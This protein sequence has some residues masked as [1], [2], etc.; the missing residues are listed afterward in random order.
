[1]IPMRLQPGEEPTP[2]NVVDSLPVFPLPNAVFFPNTLL[3]LH[4]FEPRYRELVRHVMET[5]QRMGVALLRPG[6]E[7]S[8]HEAPPIHEVM[9][10]G[11]VV[12]LQDLPDG[13]SNVLLRGLSRVRVLEELD[14]SYPFRLMRVQVEADEMGGRQGDA[15]ERQI[16]TVRQLF[17][18]V[19]ARIPQ[20]QIQDAGVLFAPDADPTFVLDSIASAVPADP[21]HKQRLLE[22]RDLVKRAEL[23]AEVLAE[24]VADTLTASQGDV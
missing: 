2:G 22:E 7:E 1:M 16:A 5:D 18:T 17:S 23:L 15:L 6:F 14:T 8:Y 9:C 4:V 21:N 12:T 10:M 3:P 19:I 24:A 11:E 20:L 13:R